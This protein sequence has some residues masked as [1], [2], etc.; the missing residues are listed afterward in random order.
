MAQQILL[1]SHPFHG[2]RMSFLLLYHSWMT[3]VLPCP[4]HYLSACYIPAMYLLWLPGTRY[5]SPQVLNP[6]KPNKDVNQ[7]FA[8][9]TLPPSSSNQS[10]LHPMTSWCAWVQIQHASWVSACRRD[11]TK[12][13]IRVAY[14]R[15]LLRHCYT[16]LRRSGQA[17]KPPT[18]IND[19]VPS[20]QFHRHFIGSN[21]Y[22]P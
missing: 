20:R 3:R 22:I 4:R 7:S 18:W 6:P 12:A 2:L 13:T 5:A 17:H 11:L 14:L 15:K 9:P 16:C 21:N 10:L 19:C 1:L 8:S